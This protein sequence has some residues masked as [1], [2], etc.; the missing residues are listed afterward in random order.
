MPA[1]YGLC[2]LDR[3]EA[4]VRFLTQ[5]RDILRPQGLLFLTFAYWDAEGQ[6]TASGARR[7][8]CGSTRRTATSA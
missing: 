1:V 2:V 7:S 6:D 4:P 3:I 5:A 8:G